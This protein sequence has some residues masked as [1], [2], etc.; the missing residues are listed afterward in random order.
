[1]FCLDGR[2]LAGISVEVAYCDK[3]NGPGA[4]VTFSENPQMEESSRRIV[5]SL[6]L[7]GFH[8][9]DFVIENETDKAYLLEINP[10]Q[11]PV[12][13]LTT[14]D[15]VSLVR[16]VCE[17]LSYAPRYIAP[18][19]IEERIALFPYGVSAAERRGEDAVKLYLDVPWDEPALLRYEAF[20]NN[21]PA[22]QRLLSSPSD[23]LRH[24]R[25]PNS[26][27]R[28][29]LRHAVPAAPLRAQGRA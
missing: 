17:S 9:F 14:A 26:P 15:G 12:A 11:T 10:R 4:V 20:G 27:W 23:S 19:V 24:A 3:E 18:P 22:I 5:E 16:A 7:S 1:V 8:G 13:H 25:I 2:V 6:G 28:K 21:N 29:I